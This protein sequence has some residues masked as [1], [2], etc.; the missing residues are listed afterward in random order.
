MHVKELFDLSGKTAI[1]TG[2]GRGLGE[3]IAEG[4]AEAGANI[5]LCSRKK[6]NCD[7]VADRLKELGVE[8]LTFKCDITNPE[9][10]QTVVDET[11]QRFGKIDILVN[12]SGATWGAPVE[13]MPL[14][15]FQ[16][17][18]NV[19]VVGTFL[20]SQAVG[21]A[22]LVEKQG[23][24]INIASVAGLKGSNPELMDAIGYNSSKGGVIS[25]TK[26]LAV[27]WGPRGIHV[28][29]I[30]PGFFP[31]KM[32]KVLIERNSDRFLQR[33]PLRKF[34]SDSDLKGVALFLASGASNFITGE[35]IA[36]DG[37][38]TAM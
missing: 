2:G 13:E 24:I 15:A 3:Q 27:K 25:F 1:V 26:D 18:V 6:E 19:N 38:T 10:V 5:V 29:A 36:V 28:N 11:I 14:E 16:K 32:S 21:K 20:M 22:M 34:G 12:N 23:K 30:A 7:E 31:T 35:T 9:E 8:V 33:T 17:V 4:F 37:G